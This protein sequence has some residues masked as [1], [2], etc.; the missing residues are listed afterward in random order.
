MKFKYCPE[1]GLKLTKVNVGD[2]KDLPFC[3]SCKVPYF[4]NVGVCI[5]AAV[6]NEDKEIALLKQDYVS[7]KH[8]L[9]AGHL[10]QNESLEECCVRE[11]LEE[12]GQV[13]DT[14]KYI[15]SYTY[16]KRDLLMVGYMCLVKKKDFNN[17]PEVDEIKWVTLNDAPSYLRE[18]SIARELVETIIKENLH[19]RNT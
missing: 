16:E 15:D 14:L 5:I 1:C 17:S 11:V 2:E 7:S 18:A 9:V 8:V 10:S 13:V 12:T 3:S 19:V 6:I 4:D